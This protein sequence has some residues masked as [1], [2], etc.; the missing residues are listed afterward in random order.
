MGTEN[1]QEVDFL[2]VP[3]VRQ[4]EQKPGKENGEGYA[5]VAQSVEQ[6]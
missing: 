2:P 5:A 1:Q 4:D 6:P 3:K